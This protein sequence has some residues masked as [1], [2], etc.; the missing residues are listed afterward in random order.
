MGNTLAGKLTHPHWNRGKVIVLA[1]GSTLVNFAMANSLNRTFASNLVADC[2]SS[3]RVVFL[4]PDDKLTIRTGSA[5]SMATHSSMALLTR[6]PVSMIT[7]H[8]LLWGIFTLL[9]L[10]PIFGRAL[11]IQDENRAD[12]ANHLRAVAELLQ[13]TENEAVARRHIAD[14]F[15]LVR[16]EPD[17]H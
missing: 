2:G 13:A 9:A 14:Y 17:G 10:S 8:I 16:N 7:M 3:D 4:E 1:S 15:R 12:F 6:W 11:T 5:E